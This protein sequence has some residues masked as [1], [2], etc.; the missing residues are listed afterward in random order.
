MSREFFWQDVLPDVKKR[1]EPFIQELFALDDP[2]PSSVFLIGA[3]V[4]GEHSESHP[5][6]HLLLVYPSIDAA[7]L[8]R[9]SRL[10]VRYGKKGLRAPLL[11]TPDHFNDA[12]DSFPM[13]LL[14]LKSNHVLLCGE[15]LL[16]QVNIANEHLRL[17][18]ERELRAWQLQLRQAYLRSAGDAKWMANWYAA[19]V[20]EIFPLLRAALHLL[21]GDEQ[22]GNTEAA[23]RLEQA[24]GIGFEPFVSVY[25]RY[26]QGKRPDKAD[27]YDL[28]SAWER[29]FFELVTHIDGLE[30]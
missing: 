12:Q 6:L 22:A 29:T 1:I 23:R 11:L 5:D 3:A 14:D 20:E 25:A 17:Q 18:V 10:G 9:I 7:L 27:V 24:T 13:E 30:S 26:K 8:D 2:L 16:T 28:Y 21:G 15:D 4:R 19:N